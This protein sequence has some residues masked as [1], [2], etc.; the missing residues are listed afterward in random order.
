MNTYRIKQYNTRFGWT[1][2]IQR[3]I[4]GFFWYNILE[5]A[6]NEFDLKMVQDRLTAII[7]RE[8]E[9]LERKALGNSVL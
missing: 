6:Y 1:Y 7:Q 5:Q 8:Q 4:L 9:Y 2:K 3:K